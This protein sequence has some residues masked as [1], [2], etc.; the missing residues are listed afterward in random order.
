MKRILAA[1]LAL[2][3]LCACAPQ[4][5]YP[6]YEDYALRHDYMGEFLDQYEAECLALYRLFQDEGCRHFAYSTRVDDP[7]DGPRAFFRCEVDGQAVEL[8]DCAAG[9]AVSAFCRKFNCCGVYWDGV[10]LGRP[11]LRLDMPFAK[12][13]GGFEN[14]YF[15]YSEFEEAC[16]TLTPIPDHPHWFEFW[17]API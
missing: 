16:D 11:W 6:E 3:L 12:C 15:F 5:E 9:E 2:L 13:G 4:V 17:Q 7:E 14:A 8:K 10:E 1:L